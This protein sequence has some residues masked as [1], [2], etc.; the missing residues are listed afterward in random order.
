MKG[1]ERKGSGSLGL[2]SQKE[3]R[4]GVYPRL[5]IRLFLQLRDG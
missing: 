4:I 5:D 3:F 2:L 1:K